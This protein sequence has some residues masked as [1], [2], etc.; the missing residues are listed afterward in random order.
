MGTRFYIATPDVN[1]SLSEIRMVY[2]Q[3]AIVVRPVR[4]PS[5]LF[6]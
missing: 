1:G 2:C 6:E 5:D 3:V 4:E